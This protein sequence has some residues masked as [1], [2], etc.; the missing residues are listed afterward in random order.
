MKLTWRG[1]ACFA[2]ESGGYSILVD[3]YHEVEGLPDISGEANEVLCSHFHRDHSYVDGVKVLGGQS[4][5]AVEKMETFHDDQEGALRGTNVVHIFSAEGLRVAHLGDLGHVPGEEHLEKLTGLDAL[6]I[7]VGGTYTLDA[8][9]AA[10]LAKRLK[11]RM[12]IPMHYRKG[13]MGYAVLQ[14]VEEFLCRFEE[15]EICR[16]EGNS[17]E[18]TDGPLPV[19]AVLTYQN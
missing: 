7:P 12:V 5:F 19:V 6:L 3:P 4:P 9:Q 16:C 13:S 17:I 15:A 1:H 14:T 11:P 18:V 10:A 2:I 8:V